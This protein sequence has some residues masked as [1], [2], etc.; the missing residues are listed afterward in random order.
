M[1][2]FS[3]YF[4]ILLAIIFGFFLVT[5]FETSKTAVLKGLLICAR[6]I[7]PS[8]FPFTVC[9]IFIINTNLLSKSKCLGFFGKFL[10]LT[11]EEMSIFLLSLFSGYPTGSK[12]LNE[13]YVGGFLE[14]KKAQI[15]I[16]YCVNAGPAFIISAVGQGVFHSKSI[17]VILFLSHIIAS[18]LLLI[19]SR[20]DLKEFHSKK[21]I[22]KTS[23]PLTDNFVLSTASAA[24]SVMNICFYVI[25]FSVVT[26]YCEK[27]SKIFPIA[28]NIT[29]LLEVTNGVTATKSIYLISFLLGFAGVSIWFQVFS[30]TKDIKPNISKF[31]TFRVLH[32]T[33]SC[34]LTFLIIKTFKIEVGVFSNTANISFN[35][36]HSNLGIGI[37]LVILSLFFVFCVENKKRSGNL[38]EDL[39]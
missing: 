24:A 19:F 36:V 10:Y 17:G 38:V 34:L 4:F 23:I 8:L 30:C 29:Y 2:K 25:F 6:I 16:N 15:L 9:L 12:L 39:L 3:N 22:K 32:G 33:V 37:A 14:N 27:V 28:K 35:F 1:K 13:L 31:A 5:D 11:A 21:V 26:A 7:I 18:F 20:K